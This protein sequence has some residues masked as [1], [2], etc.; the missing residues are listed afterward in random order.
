MAWSEA[1]QSM[2]DFA[3]AVFDWAAGGRTKAENVLRDE[4]DHWKNEYD[5]AMRAMDYQTAT[6]CMS[7]LRRVRDQA[8][9]QRGG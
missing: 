8:R 4:A 6:Y 2:A 1:V 9:A 7:Q 3:K 5:K